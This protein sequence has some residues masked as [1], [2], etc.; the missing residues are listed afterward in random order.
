MLSRQRGLVAGRS[1]RSPAAAPTTGGR[2][3]DAAWVVGVCCYKALTDSSAP[4]RR[5]RDDMRA[6]K[7]RARIPLFSNRAGSGAPARC[8]SSSRAAHQGPAAG[9]LSH[10]E[11]RG[12]AVRA[13]EH[14]SGP[15]SEASK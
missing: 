1:L 5:T 9:W 8:M 11:P 3:E 2:C 4:A 6:T 12:T 10:F 7:T 15:L 14:V 13:R